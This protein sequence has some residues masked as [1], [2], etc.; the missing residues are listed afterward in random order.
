MRAKVPQIYY[1]ILSVEC[2]EVYIHFKLPIT[3][4][5]VL[6]SCVKS[7]SNEKNNYFNIFHI[8][9]QQTLIKYQNYHF[10]ILR[11]FQISH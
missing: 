7:S 2:I 10:S 6:D 3:I 5:L 8:R 11:V 1:R 9:A 4:N